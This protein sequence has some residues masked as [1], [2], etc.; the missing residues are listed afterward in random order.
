M[1]KQLNPRY[2]VK[3]SRHYKPSVISSFL[4]S[5][6]EDGQPIKHH[7]DLYLLLR[8]NNLQKKIG[9]EVIQNYIEQLERPSAP[10][11]QLSDEQL[12]AL[13]EPKEINNITDAYQFARY[14]QQNHESVSKKYDEYKK[15]YKEVYE[16]KNE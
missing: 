10:R 8:Q 7:S 3:H 2:G 9:L 16:S 1:K 11:P 5:T 13:I 12:L 6:T 4:V 15:A 14:L